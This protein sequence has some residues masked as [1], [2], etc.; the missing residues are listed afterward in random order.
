MT[1]ELKSQD[2]VG[3]GQYLMNFVVPQKVSVDGENY[4]LLTGTEDQE[5]VFVRKKTLEKKG[6][7]VVVVEMSIAANMSQTKAGYYA[8]SPFFALYTRG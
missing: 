4:Q 7:K 8:S 5:M 2:R 1:K 3:P 6:L